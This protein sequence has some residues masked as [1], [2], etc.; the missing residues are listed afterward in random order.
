MVRHLPSVGAPALLPK[1]VDG[2]QWGESLRAATR[3]VNV[4]AR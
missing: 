3:L 2:S 4:V 1:L